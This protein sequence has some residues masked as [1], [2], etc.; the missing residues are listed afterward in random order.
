MNEIPIAL[1][2]HQGVKV[3]LTNARK[4]GSEFINFLALHPV[5]NPQGK[6]IYVI[7]VQYDATHPA[8][9]KNDLKKVDEL[10]RVLPRILQ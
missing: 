4:D 2:S 9:C 10:L 8:A 7:G 6:C 1:K 5:F 3:A